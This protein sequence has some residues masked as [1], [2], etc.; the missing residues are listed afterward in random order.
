MKVEI[1]NYFAT[2]TNNIIGLDQWYSLHPKLSKAKILADLE[3]QGWY[4]VMCNPIIYSYW[5]VRNG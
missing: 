4:W 2:P 1:R 5:L 3:K